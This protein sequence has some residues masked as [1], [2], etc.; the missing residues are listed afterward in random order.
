M[1][2]DGSKLSDEQ[3]SA[4]DREAAQDPRK[5][6]T[7]ML[8]VLIAEVRRLRGIKEAAEGMAEVILTVQNGHPPSEESVDE[9]LAAYR[10]ATKEP[11]NV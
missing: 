7:T 9:A 4:I 1:T 10:D 8:R 2:F 11:A 5:P 6:I 3:L